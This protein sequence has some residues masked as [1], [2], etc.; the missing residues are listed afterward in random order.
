MDNDI[1]YLIHSPTEIYTNG[2]RYL[3][4]RRDG[5]AYSIPMGLKSIDKPFAGR[6]PYEKFVPVWPG[7]MLAVIGRPGNGKTGLMMWWART[8]A[9]ELQ[10]R[11]ELNRCVLYVTYEQTTEE[12]NAFNLAAE[13][14]VSI[15]DLAMGEGSEEDWNKIKAAGARRAM[16]PL[17]FMG[18]SFERR[19]GRKRPP[20]S[21]ETIAAAI[22]SIQNW[23][24]VRREVDMVFVDYLQRMPVQGRAESKTVAHSEQLDGLKDIAIE[25]GTRLVVGVQAKREVDTRTSPIP[26]QEDGQWTSNIEQ[27]CDGIITVCRPRKYKQEGESFG[28]GTVQGDT[29]MIITIAKRKLGPDNFGRWVK[30][31]PRYN[32][33]D[34]ME[35]KHYN[36]RCD[37]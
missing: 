30:F 14:G 34:D 21:V 24:G 16:L 9:K 37:E 6:P 1:D 8:W 23:G 7:E 32:Q 4:R 22:T 5:S 33:L 18:H 29:Q 17:W 36:L 11:G 15:T 13:T 25:M 20:M 19:N 27:S 28:S 26:N 35:E 3:A 12:L 2:E 31:D 10:R